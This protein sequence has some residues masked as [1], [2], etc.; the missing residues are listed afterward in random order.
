MRK[1]LLE[2]GIELVEQTYSEH[3]AFKKKIQSM[4]ERGISYQ[5]IADALNLW[6]VSTRTGDGKWHAKTVRDLDDLDS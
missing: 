1:K 2:A 4:R 5:G 6:K 3:L